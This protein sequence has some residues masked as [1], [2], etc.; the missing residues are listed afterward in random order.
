MQS[1]EKQGHLELILLYPAKLSFGMEGQ[2]KCFPD[3]VKLKEFIITKPLSYKMLNFSKKK[4]DQ[5]YEQY[6]DNKLTTI[7]NWN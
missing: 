2:I 6:N 7:N 3:K 4:D 5:S 1:H